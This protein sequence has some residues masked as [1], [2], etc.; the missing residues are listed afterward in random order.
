MISASTQSRNARASIVGGLLLFLLVGCGGQDRQ[1]CYARAE[2][3]FAVAVAACPGPWEDCPDRE[4]AIERLRVA[5]ERC[6]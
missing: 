6:P 2:A 1:A 4:A 3:G 5:Q